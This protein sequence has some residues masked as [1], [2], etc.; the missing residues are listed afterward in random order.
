MTNITTQGNGI[1]QIVKRF[2]VHDQC[3][4][5]KQIRKLFALI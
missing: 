2:I 5:R 4:L 1:D 3:H